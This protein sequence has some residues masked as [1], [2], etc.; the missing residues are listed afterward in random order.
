MFRLCRENGISQN[1]PCKSLDNP[2]GKRPDTKFWTFEEFKKV[3]STFDLTD[4]E[5]LHRLLQL[6]V[7]DWCTC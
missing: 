1:I 5:D 4:Y 6:V 7:Y 3:L 2:K